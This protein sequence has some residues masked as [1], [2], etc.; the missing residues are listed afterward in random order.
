MGAPKPLGADDLIS[1]QEKAR[2]KRVGFMLM[3][4][5]GC[6]IYLGATGRIRMPSFESEPNG[7]TVK[8]YSAD[9][10]GNHI[11]NHQ[12]IDEADIARVSEDSVYI[13]RSALAAD[14]NSIY[15]PEWRVR[16]LKP[17]T[18]KDFAYAFDGEKLYLYGTAE[19]ELAN[20]TTTFPFGSVDTTY[21][22]YVTLE[23]DAD[24]K[25]Q[26]SVFDI[27][28]TQYLRYYPNQKLV[29]AT[30]SEQFVIFRDDSLKEFE[31]HFGDFRSYLTIN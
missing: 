27:N 15:I 23:D 29:D 1:S 24:S 21:T 22:G 11:T 6:I 5:I 12:L 7:S 10:N 25:E 31:D 17:N 13:R 18:I 16:I 9:I 30:G 20:I 14:E 3:V 19:T 4:I 8:L 28:D 26:F 2:G